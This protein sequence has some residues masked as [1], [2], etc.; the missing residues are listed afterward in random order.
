MGTPFSK[1]KAGAKT[2]PVRDVVG[3]VLGAGFQQGVPA[4]RLA[5][6]NGVDELV[7]GG[8]LELPGTLPVTPDDAN[9]MPV[10]NW[11]VP[12]AFRAPHIAFAIHSEQ[13]F[14]RQSPETGEK[15]DPHMRSVS[16]A[17]APDLPPLTVGLPEFQAAWAAR[18]F[19]EGRRP[20]ACSIQVAA[21]AAISGFLHN[22]AFRKSGG[23]A[24]AMLVFPAYTALAAFQDSL[25]V[26]YREH[27]VGFRHVR[28]AVSSK[29][30]VDEA[31]ADSVLD[32][33]M[34][35]LIP[36]IEPV[37]R[38]LFRQLEISV[39]YLARRRDCPVEA[40][41]IYGLPTGFRYWSSLF[42]RILGQTPVFC[43]PLDSLAG[44]PSAALP[45]T[46]PLA[47]SYTGQLFM[48][49][50]GAAFAVLDDNA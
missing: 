1:L 13:A 19:P 8:F 39:D 36:M 12:R 27:P 37:L 31:M 33:T 18:L 11:Q 24:V 44:S 40:F 23:N 5:R 34:V 22:P 43:R 25:L 29:M 38:P 42:K 30:R 14:L 50:L 48:A 2:A 28:E 16:R 26:L 15:G 41:F 32:D 6:K 21:T 45:G 20:T 47:A 4:V 10:G 7:A 9:A 35:D 17:T 3:M 46:H 49:A